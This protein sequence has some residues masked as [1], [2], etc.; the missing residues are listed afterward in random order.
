MKTKKIGERLTVGDTHI[1]VRFGTVQYVNK[2][3]IP[4]GY[5]K[6]DGVLGITKNGSYDVTNYD[7]AMVAVEGRDIV[8]V[9]IREV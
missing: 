6:P 8:A 7:E 1:K 5:I 2:P 3:Y 4:E 9:S